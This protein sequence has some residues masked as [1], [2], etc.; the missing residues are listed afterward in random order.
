[1]VFYMQYLVCVGDGEK[2]DEKLEWLK[3]QGFE[4]KLPSNYSYGVI[5]VEGKYF[6]GGNVTCF[7][8]FMGNGN[9]CYTWEEWLQIY[10]EMN[11]K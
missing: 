9:P 2:R 4:G 8:A 7:A 3:S 10:E 5:V 1:M 11:N 6:F